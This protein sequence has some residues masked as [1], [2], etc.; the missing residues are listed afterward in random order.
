MSV[1]FDHL[2][3]IAVSACSAAAE[4]IRSEAQRSVVSTKSSITDIVTAADV[5]SERLIVDILQ[6]HTPG[7]RILAEEGGHTVAGTGSHGDVEW[8]ID[9]LDGTVNFAYRIPVTGVSIAA[10]VDGRP[11]AGAVVDIGRGEL[12]AA[13]RG[14][15]ATLDG[16]PIE[17]GQCADPSLALVASGF[18]YDAARRRRHGA[19]VASVVGAV[20]DVR[21]FGSAALHL[22]W[23]AAGRLDAYFERDIR[24]W[25]YAAGSLIAQEAGAVVELPCLENDHLVLTSNAALHPLLRVL[26]TS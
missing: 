15:G 16:V 3:D 22:C 13:H 17:V 10:V 12:F 7:A 23:V 14:G 5:A 2:R 20:R 8:V 11:A 4:A 6:Q 24:P 1:P 21:A 25:D 9:P 26:V 19:T 18:S